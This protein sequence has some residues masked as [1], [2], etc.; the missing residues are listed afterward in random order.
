MLIL[1]GAFEKSLPKLFRLIAWQVFL[2]EKGLNKITSSQWT[3]EIQFKLLSLQLKIRFQCSDSSCIF[4]IYSRVTAE[5]TICCIYMNKHILKK[6]KK[7]HF[8]YLDRCMFVSIWKNINPASYNYSV[9]LLKTSF[10][11]CKTYNYSISNDL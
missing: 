10:R 3:K 7:N 9:T 2:T 11:H 8:H 6:K 1:L 4:K 5:C